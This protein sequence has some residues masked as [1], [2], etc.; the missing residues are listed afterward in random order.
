MSSGVHI[1]VRSIIDVPM[2]TVTVSGFGV[3]SASM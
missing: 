2:A 1:C 3:I